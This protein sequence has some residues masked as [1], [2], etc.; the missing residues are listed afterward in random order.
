MNFPLLDAIGM[1][2]SH[3]VLALAEG[4]TPAVRLQAVH[5]RVPIYAANICAS[6]H[7]LPP[8]SGDLALAAIDALV[9]TRGRVL[10]DHLLSATTP[11]R[12]GS[13]PA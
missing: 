9:R 12:A 6:A 4:A 13:T 11:S 8:V 2:S 3:V 1:L 7:I 5:H 10:N